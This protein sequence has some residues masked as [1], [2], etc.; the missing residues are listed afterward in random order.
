MQ[1][2]RRVIETVEQ[3]K[4]TKAFFQEYDKTSEWVDPL[5]IALELRKAGK[6][7]GQWKALSARV[8]RYFSKLEVYGLVLR[9]KRRGRKQRF[10]FKP[11]INGRAMLESELRDI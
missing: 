4:I 10:L 2:D 3:A 1:P 7:E 6:I 9:F 8:R 11:E 5:D